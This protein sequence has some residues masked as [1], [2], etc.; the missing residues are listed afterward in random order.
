MQFELPRAGAVNLSVY[1]VTGRLIVRLID[2]LYEAGIHV[3]RLDASD[4]GPGVYFC[5]LKASKFTAIQK[6]IITK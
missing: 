1:A 6:V 5:R 2:G 3:V 4:F